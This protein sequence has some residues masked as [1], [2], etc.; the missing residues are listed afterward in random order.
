M[1]NLGRTHVFVSLR[2]GCN[3]VALGS[4]LSISF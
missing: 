3:M 2:M 4:P 1:R